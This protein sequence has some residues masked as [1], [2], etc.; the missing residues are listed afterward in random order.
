MLTDFLSNH[1]PFNQ[2]LAQDQAYLASHLKTVTFAANDVI[3]SP[4]DG[5]ANHYFIIQHGHVRGETT[6]NEIA[7]ELD[8]GESFPIGALLAQRP[9][10]TV[11]KAA[12]ETTCYTLTAPEFKELFERSHVFQD[13]CTRRLAN[14][15]DEVMRGMQADSTSSLSADNSLSTPLTNLLSSNPVSCSPD[16][17]IKDALKQIEASQRRS[18]AIVNKQNK[19]VGILTLRDVLSRVTL[20]GKDISAPI[21]EVMTPIE[22]TLN[23]SDFAY[24]AVLQMAE[25]G[26]GHVCIVD[27]QHNFLGLLSERDLFSL[28]RV[29]LGN[30]SRGI[31]SSTS[32]K[33]LK[34]F[35][36]Q[37]SLF[38][39]QMLAQGAS[40]LQLTKLITTLNDLITQKVINLCELE[41]GKPAIE[42]SWLSFGSE[43]REEQTLKTDQDNGILFQVPDNET[44]D[45]YRKQ[46]LPLARRINEALDQVGFPLCPGN[47][48]AS[49]PECC[50]SYREW[51]HRFQKWIDSA[52][53]ENLLNASIFFDFRTL[54]GNPLP[55]EELFNWLA[56]KTGNN[57]LFR[58]HMA[59]NALRIRPPL[60]MFSNFVVS[61]NKDNPNSFDLK[62]QGITPFVDAARIFAL[63]NNINATNTIERFKNAADK[64]VLN[65]E[66][67]SAWIE[68]YQYIQLLRMRNHREQSSQGKALSNYINPDKLNELERRI[69]KEA[70]RQARKLQ[71]KVALDYQL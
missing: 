55:A 12:T 61:N 31:Q 54:Y 60:G 36:R 44:E 10:H 49:N 38:A 23:D 15:L 25:S 32:I 29:G 6:S 1:S 2:M 56:E 39:D 41:T 33:Q 67:V 21:S 59:E 51:Q 63:A 13:F 52:S 22:S 24:Q 37:V 8:A 20:A 26:I 50:L 17:S 47:I 34:H 19:P 27:N 5:N 28:Q 71:S 16:T 48:M 4:D 40:V 58:R 11:V 43:G 14:M 35:S 70:F 66:S 46:L 45:S 53:P 42:Y 62:L 57:S 3:T 69:L 68:A 64:G 18:I 9:V 7:W 65:K 30:L